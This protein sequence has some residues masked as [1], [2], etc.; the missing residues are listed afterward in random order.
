MRLLVPLI[1]LVAAVVI[2]F[3][4]TRSALEASKPLVVKRAD[5]EQ[6]LENARKIQAVR[7]SLQ[8]RYNA[9][10][11]SDL[12]RLTKLLPSHVDNVRLV[13]DING[14]AS[15]YGMTIKNIEIGQTVNPIENPTATSITPD[16]PE[17][18]DIRFTVS[19]GYESL[20]SFLTD[21]GRSLRIVDITDITFSSKD[22]DLY[23]FTIAL[24]TYWLQDK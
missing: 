20:K 10:S 15:T 1:S 6:A 23:D 22:I 3:G 9:F 19:G 2:F 7:E 4:P 14:M 16:G 8:E 13:I 17:H 18:L 12:G 5:L 24:R 11:S 21:L